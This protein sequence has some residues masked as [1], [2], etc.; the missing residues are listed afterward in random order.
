[1]TALATWKHRG[2]L[3]CE[4]NSTAESTVD[5]T[6]RQIANLGAKKVEAGLTVDTAASKITVAAAG[7]YLVVAGV[8]FS[9]TLSKTYVVEVYIDTTGTNLKLERKLGTGGDVGSAHVSGII[10]LAAG[11]DVSIYQS[12][13]DGGSAFTI[14]NGQLSVARL[15]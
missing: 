10:T 7:D 3:Y 13:T 9:G 14:Q 8:C 2:T 11:E 4:D 15:S 12:T 5:A 6:P 1:M